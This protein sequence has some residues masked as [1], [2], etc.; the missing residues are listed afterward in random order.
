MLCVFSCYEVWV[1]VLHVGIEITI[2]CDHEEVNMVMRKVKCQNKFG[3][4]L[5]Q[6]S[7]IIMHAHDDV[8]LLFLIVASMGTI[9]IPTNKYTKINLWFKTQIK[10][11]KNLT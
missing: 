10:I 5:D 4:K 8:F 1:Y 9:G 6:T 3:Y 7:R 11:F 2:E